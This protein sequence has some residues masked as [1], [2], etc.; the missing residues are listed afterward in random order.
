MPRCGHTW[1]PSRYYQWQQLRVCI[2]GHGVAPGIPPIAALQSNT[3]WAFARKIA[4]DRNE[5]DQLV[6]GLYAA[7]ELCGTDLLA[8]GM[9]ANAHRIS[10]FYGDPNVQLNRTHDTNFLA[11]MLGIR[12]TLPPAT[13]VLEIQAFVTRTPQVRWHAVGVYS[14][15]I[16]AMSTTQMASA[17]ITHQA[18]LDW[19][20]QGAA[21]IDEN[22]HTMLFE[23]DSPTNKYTWRQINSDS[24]FKQNLRRQVAFYLHTTIIDN[25][26]SNGH[27]FFPAHSL[28]DAVA[29]LTFY[30]ILERF[31]TRVG[32]LYAMTALLTQYPLE[33]GC[34]DKGAF[35]N[36]AKEVEPDGPA[37][38]RGWYSQYGDAGL[39]NAPYSE[40]P[41]LLRMYDWQV[42]QYMVLVVGY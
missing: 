36:I 28:V 34:S 6:R 39:D 23:L 29:E 1:L 17:N 11:R 14:A 31:A 32:T 40:E 25:V 22:M 30:G 37:A 27:T 16:R 38:N 7:M 2:L 5:Q 12:P 21:E 10:P 42:L 33:W 35:F 9:Q 24:L 15:M 41:Y 13:T 18:V 20:Q 19:C 3:V 26:W 8:Q 4:A